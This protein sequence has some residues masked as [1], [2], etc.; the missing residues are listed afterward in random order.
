MSATYQQFLSSKELIVKPSGFQIDRESLPS[1]M[2]EFQKDVTKWNISKGKSG[3]FASTGL[4]KSICTLSFGKT[5]LEYTNEP[6]LLVTPLAVGQQ[7]ID[8]GIKFEIDATRIERQDQAIKG[9]NI[10]NYQKLHHIDPN[11]YASVILDE[12]SILKSFDGKTRNQLIQMFQYTPFR[13]A[14]T[15]TPS[16]ND[17]I[18]LG[19]YC[20]FLGIMSRNEMLATFFIHD[21][22]DTKSWRL[23]RHAEQDFWKW[24]SSWAVFIRHPRDLGYEQSG[25]D[26]PK[27]N[28]FE[29]VIEVEAKNTLFAMEALDLQEARA[30]RRDSLEERC[31]LAAEMV[32]NSNDIW[33]LWC[34]LNDE[35]DLLEKL[36]PGS[37]Q[38]AGRHSDE[39]KENEILKFASGKTR[40]LISKSSIIGFGLNLQVCHNVI[41]VG[42]SHSWESW[43]Q[44]IKRCHRFGQQHEVNCHI[45]ISSAEGSVLETIKRK[46][47]DYVRMGNEITKY[48]QQFVK[49]ELEATTH[50]KVEY[51]TDTVEGSRFKLMLGDC[52]ER[53]KEIP[54]NSIDLTIS[55]FP[56]LGLYIYSNS[57]RDF[58][59]CKNKYQFYQQL[60][61]L[62]DELYRVTKPGRLISLHCM[63]VQRLKERDGDM[64]IEDFR[65]DLTR[66]MIGDEIMAL[67][68]AIATLQHRYDNYTEKDPLKAEQILNAITVMQ[69]ELKYTNKKGF[70]FHSEVTIW[71]DPVTA[72][73]RTNSLKLLWKQIKKDSTKSANGL[74]DYVITFL[75]P[76]DNENPVFHTP[77]DYPVK[78]WQKIASPVWMDINPSKTLQRNS[79]RENE[80]ERHIAPLQEQVVNNLLELYSNKNDLIY[81]PFMGI[82]SV[83]HFAIKMGRRAL[84]SELKLSYFKQ[85]VL[86]CQRAEIEA[87]S[88]SLLDL[89]GDDQ[90]ESFGSQGESFG[91]I[92]SENKP[93]K[94]ST[95]FSMSNDHLLGNEPSQKYKQYL[96][97]KEIKDR[98]EAQKKETIFDYMT[99]SNTD[100]NCCCGDPDCDTLKDMYY[101]FLTRKSQENSSLRFLANSQKGNVIQALEPH[102]H[103][104]LEK[105]G[106]RCE[107]SRLINA[108]DEG[109]KRQHEQME[110]LFELADT[111]DEVN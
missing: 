69:E 91:S 97:D 109:Q 96:I 41:F 72:M 48:T 106:K 49:E 81:D 3:L 70:I 23:K 19:N 82:G 37:V 47:K 56:F 12:A 42:L 78:K 15:A 80:D 51:K 102:E 6:V 28:M 13:L 74:C 92:E 59:N 21:G 40:V 61:F 86:N 34:D 14:A 57:N 94:E 1:K 77:E 83:G 4:G 104:W 31:K 87:N 73:Q 43:H 50:Q 108:V 66:L 111:L 85:A 46:E 16:P 98:Q 101:E 44:S 30:A 76:G 99:L 25:Y 93:S 9:I 103:E 110:E 32:N 8:E 29:H 27:L 55:S 84:G 7:F 60:R 39:F 63:N 67:H 33:L 45:I 54:D 100:Y 95:P 35:G 107:Q 71:K 38:I 62:I 20:E 58:G 10:I 105:F 90:G 22:G 26:L 2:F 75:K 52:V 88:G 79:A 11:K 17:F 89:L 53:I 64:G 24:V 36:I 68:D 65:G 18:E 5:T